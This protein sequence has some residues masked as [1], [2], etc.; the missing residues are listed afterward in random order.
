M[1]SKQEDMAE[2]ARIEDARLD[3]PAQGDYDKTLSAEMINQDHMELYL[4]AIQKYPNDEAIDQE[5]ERRLK[6][7]LDIRLIPLLGICYFFYVR[8][9][10]SLYPGQVYPDANFDGL[11]CRQDDS[12][13][14]GNLWYQERPSSR[15]H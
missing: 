12:L 11:V 4:E 10:F 15:G 3:D 2:V 7:K 9:T 14:C 1:N 5:E 8:S 6:R 13:L